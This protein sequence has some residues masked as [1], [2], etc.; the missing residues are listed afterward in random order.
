MN[1]GK[2]TFFSV[3]L[4]AV[5]IS[6]GYALDAYAQGP[7]FN[8]S[9]ASSSV[10]ITICQDKDLSQMDQRLSDIYSLAR[11]YND[12][13]QT[14]KEQI[15]SSQKSWL[16]ERDQCGV[17]QNAKMCL[18]DVYSHRIDELKFQAGPYNISNDKTLP[19]GIYIIDNDAEYEEIIIGC[20]SFE[21]T[22]SAF[23][24]NKHRQNLCS[25]E[26]KVKLTDM[27]SGVNSGKPVGF[28]SQGIYDDT[29]IMNIS[30]INDGIVINS[31]GSI[32]DPATSERGD[33]GCGMGASFLLGKR[34]NKKE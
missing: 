28:T 15:T 20:D 2:L 1:M 16:K 8:C 21:C 34:I 6:S 26:A 18:S 23:S 30:F 12:H 4:I 25:Y 22:V 10:E 33:Y 31:F 5:A 27:T 14:L 9:K 19:T 17:A 24:L 13:D 3:I 29:A 7:S 11:K 32:D